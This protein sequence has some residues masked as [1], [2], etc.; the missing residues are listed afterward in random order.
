MHARRG[1]QKRVGKV[2]ADE[3]HLRGVGLT[4]ADVWAFGD[5][6]DKAL[7]GRERHC[8]VIARPPMDDLDCLPL[9]PHTDDLALCELDRKE[10]SVNPQIED[11][12][13]QNN[14]AGNTTVRTIRE[15]PGALKRQE[16]D[17]S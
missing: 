6:E 16:V 9:G 4:A 8:Q 7:A 1:E 15:P 3:A 5:R 2:G 10:L 13:F 17:G 11:V 14:I 12:A